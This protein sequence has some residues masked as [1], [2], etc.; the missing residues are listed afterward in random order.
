MWTVYFSKSPT[1]PAAGGH[2]QKKRRSVCHIVKRHPKVSKKM[3]I[4]NN[5][6][7]F[8]WLL[9]ENKYA[10]ELS[11]R[12]GGGPCPSC[13]RTVGCVA[14]SYSFSSTWLVICFV[15]SQ[16]EGWETVPTK[17]K[18]SK[19]P[20]DAPPLLYSEFSYIP[21]PETHSES[22]SEPFI[23]L[24]MGLPGAG[25]STFSCKLQECLPY[26]YI[27]INQDELGDRNSCLER[28]KQALLDGKCPVIDR[29]NMNRQQRS[30]FVELANEF[31]CAVD[32]IVLDYSIE[33]CCRRCRCRRNHPTLPLN[34]VDTILER[35]VADTEM[36]SSK[37]GLRHLCRVNGDESLRQCLQWYIEQNWRLEECKHSGCAPINTLL[38]L[39]NN[40]RLA[41]P[42]T[43]SIKCI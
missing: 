21:A 11:K 36:P 42:D 16:E 7:R 27:R 32:C 6:S 39:V 25:K 38:P 29:C 40:I 41:T 28:T 30:Y 4:R 19:R 10:A 33:E 13:N 37:E 35:M 20:K 34:Q 5:V 31:Q 15:M 8:Q 43:E 24:L 14:L 12:R 22:S 26:K 2:Q 17:K 3:S 9:Y 1:T 23:L 18:R